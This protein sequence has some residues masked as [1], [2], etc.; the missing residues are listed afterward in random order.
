[1]GFTA[2]IITSLDDF[3]Y[4]EEDWNLLLDHVPS[5]TVFQGWEWQSAWIETLCRE[6]FIITVFDD[7]ELIAILPFFKCSKRFF[8]TLQLTGSRDSDY[9]DFLIKTG[10]EEQVISFFFSEVLLK[11]PSIGIV[12]LDSIPE[13]SPNRPFVE[14]ILQKGTFRVKTREKACPF[15]ELPTNWNEYL[16]SLSSSTRYFI[17]R[18]ER[19]LE[20]EF[21][22]SFG[23]AETKEE[24]EKRMN[25]FI[26]QHQ[27]RWKTKQRPGAFAKDSFAGF[28]KKVATR[29]FEQKKLRLYYLELDE[30]PVASYYLFYDN[31]TFYF[32]LSGF[33]PDYGKYSVSSV[34]MA[35]AIL[36]A[37]DLGLKEFDLMRGEGAYKFKWTDKK[38]INRSYSIEKK[39]PLVFLSSVVE[40][41]TSSAAKIIKRKIP[42]SLKSKIRALLPKSLI[43]FLD[44]YFQE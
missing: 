27:G 13:T 36:D 42:Y 16:T 20:K 6:L 14:A 21:S 3:K 37:I 4:L 26:Q 17:N 5:A 33:D 30:K 7:E 24:M 11:D 39:K 31:D 28:H 15:I 40:S 32:Y 10:C 22:V 29:L 43:K 25:D 8:S 1:M 12:E 2:K 44:P 34:L 19:K 35:R 18:K 41:F 9:L 38:R 23:F